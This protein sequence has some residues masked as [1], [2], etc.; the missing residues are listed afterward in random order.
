MVMFL[1]LPVRATVSSSLYNLLHLY[2]THKYIPFFLHPV[3]L[4]FSQLSITLP[5][6]MHT[7]TQPHT[8]PVDTLTFTQVIAS[9]GT[10]RYKLPVPFGGRLVSKRHTRELIWEGD[11]KRKSNRQ[12]KGQT[13]PEGIESSPNWKE[14][15]LVLK[16]T[17]KGSNESISNIY[18]FRNQGGTTE[19][20]HS[21]K[22]TLCY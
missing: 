10:Y 19:M 5:H 16:I 14:A 3:S 11:T 13:Q 6:L 2:N 4:V 20:R 7:H 17:G 9:S 22:D 1:P 12:V 18:L 15:D 8:P 21:S